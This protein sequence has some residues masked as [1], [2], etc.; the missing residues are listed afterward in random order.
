MTTE[1][2]SKAQLMKRVQNDFTYHPP[3]G[4]QPEMYDLIRSETLSL[5]EKLVT[6]C[7]IGRELTLALTSLEQVMFYANASIAREKK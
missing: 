3:T 1:A 7:P 5:A 6:I 2:E 4:S